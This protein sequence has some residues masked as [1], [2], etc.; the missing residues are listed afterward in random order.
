MCGAGFLCGG[1][2]IEFGPNAICDVGTRRAALLAGARLIPVTRHAASLHL[3][4][5]K[6]MIS[7]FLFKDIS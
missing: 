7:L 5:K 2:S 4:V 6:H 1:G 3:W